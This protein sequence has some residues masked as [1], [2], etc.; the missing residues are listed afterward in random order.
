M[1]ENGFSLL[2]VMI[3]L[4][5]ATIGL[6]GL[7]AGQ[8]KS[9]QYVTNSFHYTMSIMQANNTI[10]RIWPRLCELQQSNPSLYDDP[11]FRQTLAPQI[12]EYTL[13]LPAVF[14][15]ELLVT[16]SWED[17]RLDDNLENKVVIVG[18]YPTLPPG[19]AP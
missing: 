8:L 3:A 9:M 10:E 5:V 4:A 19:C 18:S 13:T 6:L 2:E 16:I 11:V 17:Q 1:K 14:S 7:A 12:D 15:N